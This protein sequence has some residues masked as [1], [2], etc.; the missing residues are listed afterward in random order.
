[1]FDMFHCLGD[2]HHNCNPLAACFTPKVLTTAAWHW[3]SALVQA[4][5]YR[6]RTRAATQT[7]LV[8]YLGDLCLLVCLQQQQQQQP[9]GVHGRLP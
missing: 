4:L 6:P 7:G 3:V 8:A 9:A 2:L 5:R 1:M